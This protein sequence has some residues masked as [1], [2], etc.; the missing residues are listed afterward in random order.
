[1]WWEQT[2]NAPEETIAAKEP[3]IADGRDHPTNNQK[4]KFLFISLLR[5]VKPHTYI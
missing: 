3:P 5:I 1:M 4:K 2:E